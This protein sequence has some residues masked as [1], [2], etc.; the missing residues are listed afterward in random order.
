[1]KSLSYIESIKDECKFSLFIYS[2]ITLH[3]YISIINLNAYI[4]F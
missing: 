1:M 2:I 3:K 4:Y